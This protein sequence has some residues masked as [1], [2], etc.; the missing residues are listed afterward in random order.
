M[1]PAIAPTAAGFLDF[2]RKMVGINPPDLPNNAPSIAMAYGLA[3]TIVNDNLRVAGGSIYSLA[4]YNLATDILINWAPDQPGRRYFAKTRKA[5]NIT[6]FI[7]GVVSA[8]ADQATSETLL[9]PEQMKMLTIGNLQNLKTSYGQQYLAL[10]Q[11]V[12][13]LWG[14]S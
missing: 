1:T 2:L 11:S 12:G 10:A 5:L 4:V 6:Q 13:T 14:M 3:V 7:P 8:S 9:V